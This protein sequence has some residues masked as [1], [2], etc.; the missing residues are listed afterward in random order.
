MRASGLADTK[1]Q[2]TREAGFQMLR[3]SI[4]V[5]DAFGVLAALLL[6]CC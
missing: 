4:P 3:L 5:E 2:D 1:K 6:G